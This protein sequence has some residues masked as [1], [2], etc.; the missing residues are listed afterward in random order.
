MNEQNGIKISFEHN[1]A[2]L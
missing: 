1:F 2:S